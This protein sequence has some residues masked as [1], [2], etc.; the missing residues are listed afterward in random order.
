[1]ALYPNILDKSAYN[2]MLAQHYQSQ[3][4]YLLPSSSKPAHSP[5]PHHHMTCDHLSDAVQD[6]FSHMFAPAL[7]L[8]CTCS[9]PC[10]APS[11]PSSHDQ[12]V[13][14]GKVE[15]VVD[16]DIVVREDEREEDGGPLCREATI[17]SWKVGGKKQARRH[18]RRSLQWLAGVIGREGA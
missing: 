2:I 11:S 14:D 10:W 15:I 4:P 3:T 13:H 1:M 9:T 6:F 8:A 16:S 5:H 17:A 12:N 18:R 7:H